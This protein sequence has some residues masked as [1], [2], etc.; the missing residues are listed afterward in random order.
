MKG[1]SRGGKVRSH[2]RFFMEENASGQISS[3]SPS[4]I[5][6]MIRRAVLL[7]RV[8]SVGRS[9]AAGFEEKLF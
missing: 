4:V 8:I 2:D 1:E 7:R 3:F 6:D 5:H 9:S